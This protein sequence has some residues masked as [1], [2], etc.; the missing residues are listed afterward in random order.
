VTVKYT[1]LLLVMLGARA[2]PKYPELAPVG[3]VTV[4]EVALQEST[5]TGASLRRPAL[6][7]WEAPNP[8]PEITT[9]WLTDPVVAETPVICSSLRTPCKPCWWRM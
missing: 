8:V 5:V 9:C 3:I 2:A 4:I 7:P 6:L 1:A